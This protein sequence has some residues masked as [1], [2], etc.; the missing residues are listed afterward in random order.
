MGKP[1]FPKF[2][3]AD[4]IFLADDT[5]SYSGYYVFALTKGRV[6]KDVYAKFT[7]ILR[8]T[9]NG[10]KIVTH[11]SGVTPTGAVERKTIWDRLRLTKWFS[12]AGYVNP[13]EP[14][15]EDG[16][17]MEHDIPPQDDFLV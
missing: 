15:P 11:N 8:K 9:P 13:G 2:D 10:V 3:G 5:A 4:V 16:L 12:N 17:M 6:T 1:N 7:Y 14:F